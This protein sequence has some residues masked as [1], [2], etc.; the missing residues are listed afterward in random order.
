MNSMKILFL[1]FDGVI[2]SFEKGYLHYK[3]D[4]I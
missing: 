4:L 3:W 2:S 1:D